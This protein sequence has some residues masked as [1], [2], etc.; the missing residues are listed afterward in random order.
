[1]LP[2]EKM[3]VRA[4]AFRATKIYPGPAGRIISRELLAWEDFGYRLGNNS[5]VRALITQ[6]MTAEDPTKTIDPR[7]HL[8]NR[9]VI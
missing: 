2:Y 7:S 3:H 1:M 4:A 9:R 6:I 8:P 5:D